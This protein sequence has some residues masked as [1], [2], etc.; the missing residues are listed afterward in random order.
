[1]VDYYTVMARAVSGLPENTAA[2][3]QILYERAR[4]A[5]V[6]TLTGQNPPVAEADIERERLALEKGIQKVEKESLLLQ[7]DES[8]VGPQVPMQSPSVIKATDTAEMGRAGALAFNTDGVT[9][10]A[11]K[12]RSG[13]T[14][15]LLDLILLGLSCSGSIALVGLIFIMGAAWFTSHILSYLIFA[16][17]GA[18]ILCG[19]GMLLPA[20]LRTA[21]TLYEYVFLASSYLFGMTTWL[22]GVL[23]TLQYWGWVGV[24]IGLCLGVVGVVPLG[25][26][27]AALHSDWLLL[28]V[29]VVG[30]LVTYGARDLASRTADQQ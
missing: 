6:A 26:V 5:L 19:I 15:R 8:K 1:M 16:A 14:L 30:T 29:V 2:A 10:T 9:Q 17:C 22:L 28:T 24:V 11:G 18:L 4:A 21:I 13:H 7:D 12:H 27:A 3:R 23:V 25:I 20:R